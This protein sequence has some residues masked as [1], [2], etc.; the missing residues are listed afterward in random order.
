MSSL[1]CLKR[2]HVEISRKDLARFSKA[3]EANFAVG[4]VTAFLHKPSQLSQAISC[5]FD[6]EPHTIYEALLA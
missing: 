3:T 6:D 1:Q 5:V 4:E 2:V